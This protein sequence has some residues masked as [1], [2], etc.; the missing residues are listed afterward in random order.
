MASGISSLRPFLISLLSA[1]WFASLALASEVTGKGSQAFQFQEYL[2]ELTE[3]TYASM[4]GSCDLSV[5]SGLINQGLAVQQILCNDQSTTGG[6][7]P[8]ACRVL[9]DYQGAACVKQ[10]AEVTAEIARDFTGGEPNEELTR[11]VTKA[12][13]YLNNEY[14][15]AEALLKD[16]ARLNA[17]LETMADPSAALSLAQ[18]CSLSS[19]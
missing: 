8:E 2:I 10:V 12:S 17:V 14:I 18:A 13:G 1:S 3:S 4:L 7:C 15:S 19:V 9:V 6:E 11:L 16:E 5:E